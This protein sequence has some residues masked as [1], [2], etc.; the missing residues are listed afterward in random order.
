MTSYIVDMGTG[1]VLTKSPTPY[2]LMPGLTDEE[3]SSLRLDI[4]KNGIRVPIDVD[5]NDNILDGH[6]R[7]WIAAELN[8]PCP[9]RIVAG[10]TEEGKRAHAVSVNVFRRNLTR[11]QRRDLVARLR[12]SG[13]ST[14]AIAEATSLPQRTVARD[15]EAVEPNG[16]TGGTVT[17]TDGKTYKSTKQKIDEARAKHPKPDDDLNP[18]SR[19]GL[20]ARVAKAREMAAEGA[21]SHQIAKA[22]GITPEAMA[23]FRKR[24]NLEVP[25]DDVMRGTRRLDHNRIMNT[26]VDQAAALD[27]GADLIDYGALDP[28][29]IEDWVRSLES[30]ISFLRTVRNRLNKEQT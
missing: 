2:Q 26:L 3:R 20:E 18:R 24:N 29:R 1:E 8:I 10:L 23:D 11:E 16:S 30:S 13:M 7:A 15:A 17:G 9:R 21:T 4:E 12:E 19:A 5:E 22:I 25:A 14:R 6:H 28:E 27:A